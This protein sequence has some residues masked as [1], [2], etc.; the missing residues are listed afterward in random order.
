MVARP[1]AENPEVS[2]LMLEVGRSDDV[3]G[4]IDAGKWATNL[5]G[6]REKTTATPHFPSLWNDNNDGDKRYAGKMLCLRIRAK[7]CGEKSRATK[8]A[9]IYHNLRNSAFLQRPLIANR[10][11][12]LWVLQGAIS[13]LSQ[14]F[15]QMVRFR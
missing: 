5:G 10:C 3:P 4:G 13:R 8:D 11:V 7:N 15:A 1:L 14:Q 12:E 9:K 6:M 2:V